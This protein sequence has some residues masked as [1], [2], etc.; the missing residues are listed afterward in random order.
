MSEIMKITDERKMQ[1]YKYTQQ[2][3]TKTWKS[4]S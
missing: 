4:Y 2:Y 1:N 3:R